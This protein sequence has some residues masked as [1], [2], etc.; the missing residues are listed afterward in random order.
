MKNF[1]QKISEMKYIFL[2]V[3]LAFLYLAFRIIM[4]GWNNP[5]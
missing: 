3:I 2:T 1:V 5:R 4:E